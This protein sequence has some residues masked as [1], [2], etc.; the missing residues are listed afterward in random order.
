[1]LYR[2]VRSATA[3]VVV[4]A[5]GGA[6]VVV[7]APHVR[8]APHT[9]IA[10]AN[11]VPMLRVSVARGVAYSVSVVSVRMLTKPARVASVG[12]VPVRARVAGAATTT[13]TTGGGCEMGSGVLGEAEEGHHFLPLALAVQAAVHPRA[14]PGEPLGRCVRH[15]SGLDHHAHSLGLNQ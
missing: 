11:S 6:S 8:V 10:V 3:R 12:A 15:V 7:T 14:H 5:V 13:T 1:M 2:K 4:A 9:R